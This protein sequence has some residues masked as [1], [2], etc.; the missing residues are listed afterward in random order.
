MGEMEV[1]VHGD[2]TL[3]KVVFACLEQSNV[4]TFYAARQD[5]GETKGR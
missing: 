2:R 1:A 4:G 3:L 5:R